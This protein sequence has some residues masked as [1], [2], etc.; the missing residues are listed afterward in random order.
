MSSL[1]L[2][3]AAL[4]SRRKA[5]KATAR[6][7]CSGYQTV[8]DA[9]HRRHVISRR[10]AF[11]ALDVMAEARREAGEFGCVFRLLKRFAEARDCARRYEA[12]SREFGFNLPEGR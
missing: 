5:L 11:Q 1:T 7:S 3:R 8:Y 10:W 6:A 4:K 2:R 9:E 12:E